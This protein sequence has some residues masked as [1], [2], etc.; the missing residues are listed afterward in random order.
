M[1]VGLRRGEMVPVTLANVPF[2]GNVGAMLKLRSLSLSAVAVSLLS[3]TGGSGSGGSGLASSMDGTGSVLLANNP[4]AALYGLSLW[5]SDRSRDRF[6]VDVL[7][8][9]EVGLVFALAVFF[10]VM[11]SV[12]G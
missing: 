11:K 1:I 9:M 7:P 5:M 2:A 3:S 6:N 8:L 4:L 12:K 10:G